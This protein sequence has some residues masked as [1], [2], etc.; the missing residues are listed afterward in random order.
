MTVRH[1]HDGDYA[2]P[3]TGRIHGPPQWLS[4]PQCHGQRERDASCGSAPG[5]LR[6]A[7]E[8]GQP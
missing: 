2:E 3:E 4:L 6:T 8:N 7:H 1:S 5:F